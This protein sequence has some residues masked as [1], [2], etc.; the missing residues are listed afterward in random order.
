[1]TNYTLLNVNALSARISKKFKIIGFF[2]IFAAVMCFYYAKRSV[3][4]NEGLSDKQSDLLGHKTNLFDFDLDQLGIKTSQNNENP[5]LNQQNTD[6]DESSPN[7]SNNPQNPSQTQINPSNS[8]QNTKFILF[9]TRFFNNPDWVTGASDE[10]G[11]EILNSINCPATNCFFTHNHTLLSDL[12]KFDAI[13][14]HAAE[15]LNRHLMPQ[16]RSDHQLYI[17]AL[18]E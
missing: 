4:S 6:T 5:E 2:L 17:M 3:D 13:A 10:A 14:F 18:L 12:T 1:M 16:M 15:Y 8:S 9:W 11:A 7:H